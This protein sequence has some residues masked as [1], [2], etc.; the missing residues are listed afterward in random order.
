MVW[1]VTIGKYG[2]FETNKVTISLLSFY[3]NLVIYLSLDSRN[4]RLKYTFQT[5]LD[6]DCKI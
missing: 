4:L 2:Y 5:G 6:I 3:T 1:F